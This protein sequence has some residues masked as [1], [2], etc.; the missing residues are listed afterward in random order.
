MKKYI[1]LFALI[2]PILSFSKTKLSDEDKKNKVEAL[3]HK[4]SKKFSDVPTISVKDFLLLNSQN[5]YIVDV[6]TEAESKVSM[7]PGAIKVQDFKKL[8]NEDKV[9]KDKMVFTYCTIGFR[10]SQYTREL[11]KKGYQSKSI[12]GSLLA[13]IHEKQKLESNGKKTNKIHVYGKQWDLV[14]RGYISVR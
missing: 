13:W 5:I 2:F 12:K 6:R 7:I 4:I 10:S 14:P 1:I 8:V 9:P 3:A 11:I